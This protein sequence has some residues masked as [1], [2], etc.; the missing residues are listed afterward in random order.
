MPKAKTTHLNH[1]S[2]GL[3]LDRPQIAVPIGGLSDG[4]NFR[5]KDKRV[6]NINLGWVKFMPTA[7]NGA[8]GLIDIYTNRSGTERLIFATLLDLYLYVSASNSVTYLSPRYETGTINVTNG[9]ADIVGAG[10]NWDP[11]L[12][13]G[14]Q[15]AFGATGI[16][17]PAY[18]TNGGWYT[19][20]T[21]TDD[22]HITLTSNYSGANNAAIAYTARKTFTGSLEDLWITATFYNGPSGADIW[23]ATNGKDKIVKW[24]GT[25]TQVSFSSVDY[26]AK[27]ILSFRNM[28]IYG[29]VT[30]IS[31]GD[32]FP[33]SIL[34]SDVGL[35]EDVSGGLAGQF[36]IHDGSDEI[37]S[38]VPLSD[39]FV[40]YSR[41]HAVLAQFVGDPLVFL[42]RVGIQDRGPIASKAVANFG[43]HHEFLGRDT[44]YRFDGASLKQQNNHVWREVL[45]VR[46]PGR[47]LV[48]YHHFDEESGDLIW[49]VPLSTDTSGATGPRVA[50]VEH[51][52]EDVPLGF[53]QPF[54]KRSF[55]FTTT[56]FYKRSTSLTWADLAQAWSSANFAWNDKFF[57]A[58]FPLSLAGDENGYI[59][60]LGTS[61]MADDSA[62]AS[63]I[64]S[65][66]QPLADGR[67]RALISRIYPFASYIP[68]TTLNVYVRLCDHAMGQAV[69]AGPF[70]YDGDQPEGQH[71]VAAYRRARYAEVKFAT[72]SDP[73]ELSGWDVDLRPGGR[74]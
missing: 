17:D 23:F 5:I 33:T 15:I 45:R 2:Y 54:S 70:A 60:T 25:G 40:I 37:T 51:Y 16:V 14:D 12:K 59:Y 9:S 36:Q 11:E 74:R 30:Q 31:T 63:Y 64:T 19:V 8:V 49:A 53:G 61:Q 29:N 69:E 32:V 44:G 67:M 47:E 28:M 55:P 26:K 73:W 35:P 58:A 72:D 18:A 38:L 4:L 62:L 56:G 65:G 52:L 39:A 7:L 46:D 20:D 10:T 43:D 24:D 48:S 34:N 41:E 66:R 71:F 13:A 22:T 3:Y 1:G 42:F 68:N 50:Y 6:S 21:R 57:L 27:T